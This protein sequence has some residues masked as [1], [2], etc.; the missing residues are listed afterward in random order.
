[1]SRI[2]DAWFE[3]VYAETLDPWDFKTSWYEARKR[4]LTLAALPRERYRSAFEPGCALGLLT[5]ELAKRCDRLVSTDPITAMVD[6]AR[7]RV[8]QQAGSADQV[9]IGRAA[10]PDD[11]PVPPDHGFD[12]IVLSEVAYYL[13]RDGLGDLAGSVAD[14][15]A[16]GGDVVAV[17]WTGETDYPSTADAAHAALGAWPALEPWAAYRQPEFRLDVWRRR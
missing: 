13:D 5:V 3:A 15:T 7:R 9:T 17:H 4:A 16:S 14:T 1:M 2:D 6:Q 10:V 12:L 11:W 8:D